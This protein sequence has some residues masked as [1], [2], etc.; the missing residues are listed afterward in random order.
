MIKEVKP[1]RVGRI[2]GPLKVTGH[3]VYT[4]DHNFPG[5]LYAV[6]V[7]AKIAKGKIKKLDIA[8]AKKMPGV[9]D[10]FTKENIGPLYRP[11]PEAGF[12]YRVDEARP[13]F[14]DDEIRYY[15]QYIALVVAETF[16]IAQHAA[17]SVKATYD[18]KKPNVS[19]AL[20]QED[21]KKTDSERGDPNRAFKNA[22]VKISQTYTTPMEVHNPIELHATVATWE[23]GDRVTIFET[24]QAIAT[25]QN[26]LAQMVGVPRE[27]VRVI[28]KF[29][30]S[31]FGGKLW[32]WTHSP[33]AVAA[34]RQTKRPVK[35]VI[36][37]PMAFTNVGHRPRTQQ[38]IQISSNE[39]GEL[40]SLTHDY[41]TQGA[42]QG[43]YKENCG[44]VSGLL[45]KVPNVRVTS[46]VARRNQGVPTSMRGPGAVPGLFALESALDELAVALKMDPVQLRL[47]NDTLVDPSNNKKFS[48]RHLK[49]CLELGAKKFGWEK[50]NP[51]VGSMRDGEEILGWGVAG[52]TWHAAR[53]DA[54][55]LFK[56][57][58][59]GSVVLASGTTDLGTGM[60]TALAQI[61]E[62]ETGLPFSKIDIQIGDTDLPKGPL[63]G[64][65][66]AT[67]S[68]VPAVTE[69]VR[70]AIKNLKTAAAKTPG[71]PLFGKK[72]DELKFEKGKL[73][74]V[75]FAKLLKQVNMGSIEGK[76][77]SKGTFAE[78]NSEYS[79]RSFGSQFVEVGWNPHLARLRVR[80]VVTVIDA[81][82][83]INFRP[84]RN[85]IE[86]GVVMGIGMGLFEEGYLDPRDGNVANGNL[87]DYVMT[88]HA[89]CPDIDVTFLDYP[90]KVMNEYGAR[91]VGEIGL[92]GVAAAITSAVYHAT[93]KRVRDL[94]VTIEKLLV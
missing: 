78:K 3:A 40:Q 70:K 16:E 89:D 5:L 68:V 77:S 35:L 76:G 72:E 10:V 41:A 82:R 8:A 51:A 21:L 55:A 1:S 20:E 61:V 38:K 69:A 58:N 87:A 53:L 49:E 28:T 33:L 91:G 9:I 44:E 66:M 46:G 14:E 90:D 2:D 57:K 59:D 31:G 13:P 64:G 4:S 37:R 45:Y 75:E 47:L 50:R 22:A 94:P 84:A 88:V 27:N 17:R 71:S 62:E 39:K 12:E 85:Q 81:G 56:F 15:G 48:S 83:I 93:G 26:V 24:S 74:G 63:A 25:H 34:A 19:L 18:A 54:E 6:P 43:D 11:T 60:Y 79:T 7:G 52:C 86:G 36:D 23:P 29:L 92:A 65:S 67:G 30:G 80:R 73:N 42:M 32:A